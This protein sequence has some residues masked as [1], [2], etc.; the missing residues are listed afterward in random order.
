MSLV[1][2]GQP[3]T[4]RGRGW[5]GVAGPAAPEGRPAPEGQFPSTFLLR[6]GHRQ[7][8]RASLR[9]CCFLLLPVRRQAE[10]ENGLLRAKHK[11]KQ[12][13]SFQLAAG[14]CEP[15]C[16]GKPR[17]KRAADTPPHAAKAAQGPPWLRSVRALRSSSTQTKPF[18]MIS[19]T[20]APGSLHRA[21]EPPVKR[22]GFGG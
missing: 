9:D 5:S 2:N 19:Q 8:T 18:P 3:T 21:R 16:P 22:W 20:S 4:S 11:Y 12:I 17:T 7:C 1:F 10:E 13:Q 14:P 15:L 6:E